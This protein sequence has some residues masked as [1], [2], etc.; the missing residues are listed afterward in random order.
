[1]VSVCKDQGGKRGSE[2]RDVSLPSG[3]VARLAQLRPPKQAMGHSPCQV[4]GPNDQVIG[5]ET[6]YPM[7]KCGQPPFDLSDCFRL[8]W[9]LSAV[10][11]LFILGYSVVGT[12]SHLPS[13]DAATS[14]VE[15]TLPTPVLVPELS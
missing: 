5:N 6:A 1:M 14:A 9:S 7:L 11:Q 10:V 4:F 3:Q 2:T 12:K 13:S 8:V 15:P